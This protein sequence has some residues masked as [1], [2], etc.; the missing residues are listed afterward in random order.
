[1]AFGLHRDVLRP[2]D[3]PRADRVAYVELF[4]DLVYVFA[5]TQLSSYLFEHQDPL[6]AIEGGAQ[7]LPWVVT[8]GGSGSPLRAGR[9]GSRATSMSSVISICSAPLPTRNTIA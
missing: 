6:G 4:F 5:L 8:G 3:S 2:T 1:M 9:E 7:V